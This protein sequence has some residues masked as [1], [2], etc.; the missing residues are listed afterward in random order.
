MLKKDY[1]RQRVRFYHAEA[2]RNFARDTVPEGTFD[3]LQDEV[4][5]GVVDISE[6]DHA[7]GF[8][9]MKATVTQASQIAMTA[10]PLAPATKAQDRQGIC[11]QLA[12]EDRL[13][14]VPDHE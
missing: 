3:A 4:Y 13:T 12:N 6:S 11:H 10:N 2:L 9:R 5:H 8:D 14:W 1:L 7:S